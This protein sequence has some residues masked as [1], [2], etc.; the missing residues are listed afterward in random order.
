MP[1]TVPKLT[2]GEGL[3]TMDMWTLVFL[4]ESDKDEER[5]GRWLDA[6]IGRLA[7]QPAAAL[8]G[9][10]DSIVRDLIKPT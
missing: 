5:E 8:L 3:I 10:Y 1:G 6:L 2:R 9:C 7:T 4:S